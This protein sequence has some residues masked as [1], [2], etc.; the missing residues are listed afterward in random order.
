MSA[1]PIPAQNHPQPLTLIIRFSTSLPDFTLPIADANRTTCLAIKQQIRLH[2][3]PSPA[4]ESRIRLIWGGKVLPDTL[5]LGGCVRALPAP[6]SAGNEDGKGGGITPERSE[7][8]RGKLP[9]RDGE[10][11]E[12][13]WGRVYIHC[14]LGETLTA[15]DLAAETQAAEEADLALINSTLDSSAATLNA[16]SAAIT[17]TLPAPRGFDRLLATGFT[18]AEVSNLRTQFL[19][20]QSHTH[21]PDNLPQGPELLALEE[22][23]LDSSAQG[24]PSTSEA[25]AA[26]GGLGFAAEDSGAL[27]DMLWGNLMGFFWPLGAAAWLM[28]EEG[29]WTRRRQVAV[30]SGVLVNF[31][32]GVLRVVN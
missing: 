2:L 3:A 25:D 17:T 6:P 27:E 18:P 8:A 20:I 22:R 13:E 4:A 15:S 1:I 16:N 12:V 14:A 28:R 10:E 21:T 5:A 19:A 11:G 30:V 7:K 26:G 29:V 31:C 9:V 23:W 32:F 24:N